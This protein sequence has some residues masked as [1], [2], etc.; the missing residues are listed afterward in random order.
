MKFSAIEAKEKKFIL[1]GKPFTARDVRWIGAMVGMLF[2]AEVS[3]H[4]L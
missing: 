3:L 1:I 2:L 4:K